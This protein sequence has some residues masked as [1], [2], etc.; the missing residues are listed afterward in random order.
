MG[1]YGDFTL[2]VIE[3]ETDLRES[4]LHLPQVI[5]RLFQPP[6]ECTV[7]E[8]PGIEWARYIAYDWVNGQGEREGCDGVTLMQT[9]LRP[10][11]DFAI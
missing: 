6:A 9:G 4:P 2:A 8:V 10:Q 1:K 3:T 7:I 5:Q 11:L